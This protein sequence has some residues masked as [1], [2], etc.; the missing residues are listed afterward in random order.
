[1]RLD[2]YLKISRLIKRRTIAKE[3]CDKGKININGRLAKSST[4]VKIGDVLELNF[5][6]KLIKVR[7]NDTSS[8]TPANSAKE[9][10]EIIEERRLE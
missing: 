1:M 8:T 2:K 10:Y 6:S 9:M 7:I 5:G 3:V 4:E